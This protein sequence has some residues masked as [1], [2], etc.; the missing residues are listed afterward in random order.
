VAFNATQTARAK[1]ESRLREK[2]GQAIAARCIQLLFKM[3]EED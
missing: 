3:P 2:G 1:S